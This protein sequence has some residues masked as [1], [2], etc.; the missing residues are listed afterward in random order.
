MSIYG[1]TGFT[2]R[3]KTPLHWRNDYKLTKKA[4]K[5]IKILKAEKERLFREFEEMTD[6]IPDSEYDRAER[7]LAVKLDALVDEEDRIRKAN[8]R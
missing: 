2:R 1:S 8:L 3:D 4:K 7:A 6:D 5:A